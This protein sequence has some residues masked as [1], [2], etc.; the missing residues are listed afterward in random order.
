MAIASVQSWPPNACGPGWPGEEGSWHADRVAGNLIYFNEILS[1]RVVRD[2]HFSNKPQFNH[3]RNVY[4]N[5]PPIAKLPTNNAKS[6]YDP[7]KYARVRCD[8]NKVL[9]HNTNVRCFRLTHDVLTKYEKK[10]AHG[11]LLIPQPLINLHVN[12]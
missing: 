5:L 9:Q 6:K 2:V 11:K 1:Y 8:I 3:H 7:T 12:S 10:R 4:H